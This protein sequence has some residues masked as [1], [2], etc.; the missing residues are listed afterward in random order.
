[1]QARY[2][3]QGAAAG[4]FCFHT[5]VNGMWIV[6]Q[7]MDGWAADGRSWTIED[8][9]QEAAAHSAPGII[10][11]DAE[12][13]LLDRQ[14]PARINHELDLRGVAPIPDVA[15][16]EPLFARVIFESLASRYAS[17]LAHLE[18]MLGRKLDSI[19]VIGGGS[20]NKLLTEL[21][22]QRTGLPVENGEA[23]SSTIG[24]FAVQLAASE[25]NRQPLTAEAIRHWAARLCQP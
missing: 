9:V 25:A 18:R 6:K 16:N 23:E 7:C 19:H 1:M 21:T 8:L 5:N 20:R 15:G 4:G 22:A 24:N 11:V 3:N 13:L 14:M 2:T 12:E 17:A 10:D